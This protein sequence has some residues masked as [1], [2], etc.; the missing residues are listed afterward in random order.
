MN[1][2]DEKILKLMGLTSNFLFIEFYSH[3]DCDMY[4]ILNEYTGYREDKLVLC[5]VSDGIEMALDLAIEY[6]IIKR[7]FYE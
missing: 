2:I 5:K 6:I 4:K 7:K 1:I 3:E